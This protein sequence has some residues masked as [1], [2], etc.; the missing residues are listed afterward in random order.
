M[1]I[2]AL[3][4]D[5]VRHEFPDD[6]SQ[7][8]VDAA[9]KKYATRERSLS[10][11]PGEALHS[12]VPS[13]ERFAESVAQPFI[14]PIE[15]A[16]ALK[17]V[18]QGALEKVGVLP[19]KEHEQYVD[20]IGTMIKDRYGSWANFKRTLATDPVG[21][22]ADLSMV[23]TGGG[24]AVARAPGVVGKVGEAAAAAGRLAP[25]TSL[26][27]KVAPGVGGRMSGVGGEAIT[28][29]YRAGQEGGARGEA[30]RAA[31]TG[32]EPITA[33]VDDA[34][35]ALAQLRQERGKLY[36]SGMAGVAQDKTVLNFND[37]DQS[38]S[39]AMRI[40]TFKGEELSPSTQSV[41][42]EMT[43]E[44]NKWKLLDPREFHT[45]EGIDAL[46]QKLGDIRDAQ[47]YGTPARTAADE[48]YQAVRSTIVKQAPAY[49]KVMQGYETASEEIR[50]IERELSLN[51][52]A[53]VDTALRKI[54]AA[55]RDN[56]NTNFGRRRELVDFLAQSGAPHLLEKI[57]GQSLK[58]LMPQGLANLAVSGEGAGALL[59][60]A[61]GNPLLAAKIAGVI[62]AHSPRLYGEVAYGAGVASRLPLPEIS[63]G[64]LQAGRV[65]GRTRALGATA[66]SPQGTQ[67]LELPDI[68]SEQPGSF[69]PSNQR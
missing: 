36:R 57:A 63:L 7:D 49:A 53:S 25:V 33:V 8:V 47:Q 18:G 42:N 69:Q 60:L 1:T 15:T 59:A 55:L 24:S 37:I 3:S 27:G 48:I 35:K 23:L 68:P 40:K 46:K 41:R 12:L 5:G 34:R 45:V 20:A 11:I 19:G 26:I 22:A 54:T 32:A 62:A 44:I 56:V 64:A 61:A 29:A 38:V 10:E 52:K 4:D 67:A 66:L 6:T 31:M 13:A 9:M 2:T 28:T 58:Q 21:A 43:A 39:N 50:A 14:H 51:P 30:F 17:N 65:A 16:T